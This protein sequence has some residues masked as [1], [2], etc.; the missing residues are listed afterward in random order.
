MATETVV[1]RVV[2]LFRYPVKSMGA[3]VLNDVD[4]SWQ[5]FVGDRRWAFIQDGHQSSDFPWLTVRELP[6]MW[7]YRPSFVDPSRP[8]KSPTVVR[9]PTGAELDVVDPTLAAELGPGVRVIKQERGIFDAFPLSL[10]STRTVTDLGATVGAVLD[11]MRFRPNVVVEPT[12]DTPFPEEAWVGFVLRIG[13]LRMRVDKRDQRCVMINVDPKTT[14]R[15]PAVLRALGGDRQACLGVYGSI[16]A[17]GRV[18]L[19]DVVAIEG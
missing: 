17:P 3:Q 14:E 8:D 10:I 6:A 19:G 1:G 2:S 15:N 5:G 11:P 7:T 9:T 16:V 13:E 12:G 4:V 18:A